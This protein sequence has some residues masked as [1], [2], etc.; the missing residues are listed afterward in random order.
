[1]TPSSSGVSAQLR[2]DPWYDMCNGG[3]GGM[4]MTLEALEAVVCVYIRRQKFQKD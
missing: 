4:S 2:R 3:G 1:M